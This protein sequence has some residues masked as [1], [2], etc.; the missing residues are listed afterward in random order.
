MVSYLEDADVANDPNHWV[1]VMLAQPSPE[2]DERQLK[3]V[4]PSP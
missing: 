2:A 3:I 4:L 1:Q